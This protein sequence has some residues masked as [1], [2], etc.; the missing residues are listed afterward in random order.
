MKVLKDFN[1]IAE[2]IKEGGI[3]V[4]PTDTIYGLVGQ[5]LNTHTVDKI[6]QLRKRDKNKPFIILINSTKDLNTFNIKIDKKTTEFLNKHWP[7]KI[8]VILPCSDKKFKYLH[9]GTETLAFRMPNYPKLRSL[10]KIT[11]PLVAPSANIQGMIPANNIFKAQKYFTNNIDFYL[12]K[13]EINSTPSTIVK[14]EN[15][16]FIT[17]RTGTVKI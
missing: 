17:L 5:A 4:I 13:G 11:G 6:Y 8:S 10:I 15:N 12:D 7:G 9:R 3:G 14:Y 1:K 16:Q 2:L